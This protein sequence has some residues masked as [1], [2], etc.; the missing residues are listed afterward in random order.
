MIRNSQCVM[1][2]YACERKDL[3]YKKNQRVFYMI[4]FDGY[5]MMFDYLDSVYRR[6]KD[7]Y[8]WLGGMLGGMSVLE[9]KS[10]ADPAFERDW[11]TAVKKALN[12][13]EDKNLTPGL[14]YK[15]AVIFLED[16][17][18][19]GYIEEIGRVCED[20]K[21]HAYPDIWE[22]AVR[23]HEIPYLRFVEE[24]KDECKYNA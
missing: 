3:E 12:Q 1:R 10:T 16:Y 23:E 20:M 6:F 13:S 17:L 2:N 7:E 5:C 15:A 22:S 21:N 24:T 9:D 19:I 14:A 8:D 4:Y 11:D 18:K